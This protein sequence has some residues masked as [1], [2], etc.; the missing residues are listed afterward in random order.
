[1]AGIFDFWRPT[2]P[3]AS[4]P[5]LVRSVERIF[6][7][8]EL[9]PSKGAEAT[10]AGVVTTASP[11]TESYD[12]WSLRYEREA[13]I[14][15]IRK[16][17]LE[18]PRIDRA[19]W[20][21]GR[22]STRKGFAVKVSKTASRGPHAGRA[23]RAQTIIEDTIRR[24]NLNDGSFLSGLA[25]ALLAEGDLF[26][27]RV[28]DRDQVVDVKRMPAISMERNTNAQ[29]RFFDPANAFTQLDIQTQT[30][31]ANFSQWQIHHERWKHIPGER[32]GNSQYIQAR[33]PARQLILAEQAQLTRRIARAAL[34]VHHSVGNKDNPGSQADIDAYKQNNN[35]TQQSMGGANPKVALQDY[36]T[37]GVGSIMAI[38]GDANLEKIDDIEYLQNLYVS[39][40]N[41]PAPLLGISV[42]DINRDILEEQVSEYLK[43]VQTLTDAIAKVIRAVL[44]LA[45]L[46][47]GIDP[48]SVS[49]D[50]TFS[51]NSV[52]TESERFKRITSLRQNSRGNGK[53]SI[54]D[55]IISRRTALS[56]LAADL[57]ISDIDAELA[58]LDK[59]DAELDAKEQSKAQSVADALAKTAPVQPEEAE[60]GPEDETQEEPTSRPRRVK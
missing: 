23:N 13:T 2:E 16:L 8:S 39:A 5:W 11:S 56:L 9:A 43:E 41:V 12:L 34:R 18:D 46:L 29:D 14:Q 15:D 3:G 52:E 32:Y 19:A 42:K 58:E 47:A 40:L 24:C 6:G 54:P 22:E 31:V 25:V 4:K 59:E 17:M 26:I 55:P 10:E 28:V 60:Q 21:T 37:N 44:D 53:N 51:A 49:Y 38:P 27:Q 35:L 33:R 50:I 7:R 48:G 20:K 1:M 45:L 36:Y 57:G 30:T